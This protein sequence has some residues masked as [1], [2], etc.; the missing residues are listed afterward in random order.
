MIPTIPTILLLVF[1]FSPLFL[2][3][4]PFEEEYDLEAE[5]LYKAHA[6]IFF[7]T[8]V[9]R[10]RRTADGLE[11]HKARGPDQY[12]PILTIPGDFHGTTLTLRPREIETHG[13]DIGPW[14]GMEDIPCLE[15]VYARSVHSHIER[16]NLFFEIEYTYKRKNDWDCLAIY[17]K[18]IIPVRVVHSLRR[19]K[20][21]ASSDYIPLVY[22]RGNIPF[23]FLFQ[24]GEGGP[25]LKRWHPER[26]EIVFHLSDSFEDPRYRD[27]KE[28][29]YRVVEQFN[30]DLER[31]S[32]DIRLKLQEPSGKR[33]GNLSHNVL[34]LEGEEIVSPRRGTEIVY[35][36]AWTSAS[37]WTGE[38]LQA[39]VTMYGREFLREVPRIWEE[40]AFFSRRPEGS[41]PPYSRGLERRLFPGLVDI[42]NVLASDGGLRG[43]FELDTEARE[44]AQGV[45]VRYYY[46]LVLAHEFLHALGLGHNFGAS[47]DG[48]NFYTL[49][50][51][52][53]LGLTRVPPY[54][55]LS[56][57]IQDSRLLYDEPV[58]GHYDLAALRFSYRGEIEIFREDGPPHFEFV[59][60]EGEL[61]DFLVGER[62][63]PRR[64]KI[65][66]ARDNFC[67]RNDVGTNVAEVAMGL[68]ESYERNYHYENFGLGPNTFR[69]GGDNIW[70]YTTRRSNFFGNLPGYY[71][72]W[73]SRVHQYGMPLMVMGCPASGGNISQR[74]CQQINDH[75]NAVLMIGEFLL[76]TIMAP[77]Y[78]CVAQNEEG[79]VRTVKMAMVASY[80]RRAG[81]GEVND[82]F[83]SRVSSFF[84][85]RWGE[86]IVAQGGRKITNDSRTIGNWIDRF[87]AIKALFQRVDGP[88]SPG[89]GSW[90]FVDHPEIGRRT[91]EIF[92]HLLT[93][94]P[95]Q[96]NYS[97][98]KRDGTPMPVEIVMERS[99][100]VDSVDGGYYAFPVRRFFGLP[101]QGAPSYTKHLLRQATR[102]GV[103]SDENTR[104][105]VRDR[106]NYF[107]IRRQDITEGRPEG[108]G[109]AH[110]TIGDMIYSA[111][112]AMVLAK[113]MIESYHDLFF[114]KTLDLRT[115][116]ES[117]EKRRLP[118]PNLPEDLD[119]DLRIIYS[120]EDHLIDYLLK[121]H[122]NGILPNA[123]TLM[124][125]HGRALGIRLMMAH[126]LGEEKIR[127]ALGFRRNL[128]ILGEDEGSPYDDVDVDLARLYDMDLDRVED[129]LSGKLEQ[130]VRIFLSRLN[131][132]PDYVPREQVLIPDERALLR[133]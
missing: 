32:L 109:L 21:M 119:E 111:T 5:Y 35:G 23:N 14:E 2:V 86:E 59:P 83:D 104:E 13:F 54:T 8:F 40:M 62:L 75:R 80:L 63:R 61:H 123:N 43:W 67:N 93:G 65:C 110:M 22:S 69:D 105:S 101:E 100:R 33:P 118:M 89:Y 18:D 58:M 41:L 106:L 99:Y 26:R 98:E 52:Q 60:F 19:L 77:D 38:I 121:I 4:A 122:E 11:I 3:S 7:S 34:H 1:G 112:P 120:L 82:C 91:M 132:F 74:D 55:S 94:N 76:E 103:V 46:G 90:A 29:S 64:Y 78:T 68:L 17:E 131:L 72:L 28:T 47:F 79:Q 117:V 97:F 27:F 124:R 44:E 130:N 9:V 107:T 31:A 116:R 81:E 126:A 48:P 88:N 128:I 125:R 85:Y 30:D 127:Y 12:R 71:G 39:D 129:F 95:A 6:G 25:F 36:G 70:N 73:V 57:Y 115:I 108:E 24:E 37:P 50:E 10:L 15:R 92:S 45:I 84:R 133:R 56:D 114:L 96:V 42:P 51:A 16:G 49:D 66:G 102:W 53:D 87:L 113:E 20:D